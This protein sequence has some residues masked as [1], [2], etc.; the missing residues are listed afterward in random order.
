MK[1]IQI[2]QALAG[3]GL[4]P[5]PLDG[6]WGRQT[7]A[8]VRAFQT[9]MGLDPDGI[10]GPLTIAALFP[11]RP[12]ESG[13]DQAEIVWF[14]E[15]RRLLGTREKP[16]AGSNPDILD[17][18]TDVNVMYKGDDIPWCGLFVG[19][20]IG[21]TLDR[22]PLPTNV[23]G[24]RAWATFGIKTQPTSGAVMVFWRNSLQSGKGHVG[25]YAGEDAGAY[26]ILGGN[27]SDSVSLA[28]VSKNRLVAARWP[29]TVPAPVPNPVTVG[30]ADQLSWNEA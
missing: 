28:W 6:I 23:L 25:F 1:I 29:A 22:E 16:G 2:Q 30:R 15:A 17:W 24:A 13:L 4:K 19:H 3:L 14:K 12:A 10:V 27:Q 11:G 7:S 18:A 26:R 5:G 20:C 21:S 9:K 8:A